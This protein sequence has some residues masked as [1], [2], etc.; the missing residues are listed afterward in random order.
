MK[1]GQV[2]AQTGDPLG[3]LQYY[4]PEFDRLW[5]RAREVMER[6]GG[7]LAGAFRASPSASPEERRALQGLIG[8]S[9][10]LVRLAALDASLRA[11]VGVGLTEWLVTAI[12][13][14]VMGLAG[15]VALVAGKRLGVLLR[16]FE[17][18]P[19]GFIARQSLKRRRPTG[20]GDTQ[21]GV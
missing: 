4:Q 6:T 13:G 9:S 14:A 3:A 8:G 1:S 19:Q 10:S 7:S 2:S 18:G 20:R 17:R 12:G 16:R 21:G 11:A 15:D 5:V